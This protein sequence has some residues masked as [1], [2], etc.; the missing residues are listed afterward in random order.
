MRS[1]LLLVVG[2][3]PAGAA[4]A[5]EL[6][7]R[8]KP[9]RWISRGTGADHAVRLTR[10]ARS[11]LE[12][13]GVPSAGET[14]LALLAGLVRALG[15][16]PE[17]GVLTDARSG[18]DGVHVRIE[19]LDRAEELRF[20]AVVDASGAAR[21]CV[22]AESRRLAGTGDSRWW[23]GD[24]MFAPRWLAAG[25]AG[26]GHPEGHPAALEDALCHTGEGVAALL[27]EGAGE[28][29]M[30]RRV[31]AWLADRRAPAAEASERPRP[32]RS[33]AEP[34]FGEEPGRTGGALPPSGRRFHLVGL[35]LAKTGTT[36][37]ASR[38]GAY[39]WGHEAGFSEAATRLAGPP[40]PLEER[41]AWW[42]AR[43][44][45]YPLEVDSTSFAGHDA[46]A[47][48]AA[49]PEARFVLTWRDAPAWIDSWL[50]L[51]LRNGRRWGEH[52]WPAWQ[53]R[54]GGRLL[55]GFDAA[56]FRSPETVLSRL[57][58]LVPALLATWEDH[59]HQ[60]GAALP[61]GRS[62]VLR[63]DDLSR[64]DRA[65]AALVGVDP[66][67]LQ[68]PPYANRAEGKVEVFASRPA[69]R[70][71]VEARSA[72][73]A[74][75]LEPYV[76]RTG[77]PP[78]ALT[79]TRGRPARRVELFVASGCNLHCYFCCESARIAERRF[80]PWE[81]LTRR[82]DEAAD[83]GVGVVQFMGGEATLHPR[84]PDALRHARA[85][86]LSTYVI[87]NLL[88]WEDPGFAAAV[89]P[90]LDEVMVSQHAWGEAA[91][92]RVT[93]RPGWWARY[94]GALANARA[95]LRATVRA[96]TVLSRHSVDHLDRI[97]DDLLSLRPTTW[98]LGMGVPIAEARLDVLGE[99]LRLSEVAALRDR[100]EALADR[101]AASGCR[102]V[103]FCVPHCVLG[104]RLREQAHDLTV[105]HQ[106]LGDGASL[107]VNFWSQADYLDQPRP[108]TLARRR[109]E[110]CGTCARR[111]ICGGY[112][113]AYFERFGAG[114]LEPVP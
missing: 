77:S 15:R 78:L 56:W 89:A 72:L 10:A 61:E 113:S 50:N 36:T 82:L 90:W 98:V 84:F 107:T 54:F 85:R 39:R 17:P 68:G 81:E 69:L 26:L 9:A 51:L 2:G 33:P 64:A 83:R 8:G 21:A 80:L 28:R 6:V 88:R 112:F 18:P 74:R 32:V 46:Q 100:L 63:T 14:R 41:V 40:R 103:P 3:G 108:V 99:S 75:A 92:A 19:G 66:S 87:T 55:P 34:G 97:A 94:R 12:E 95:T 49:F 20:D 73:A 110:V 104:P 65:L 5:L 53:V 7:R 42:R 109:P 111:A 25:A 27:G 86:A 29:W 37:L 1:P 23:R 93:G 105:D 102:L 4:A 70:A 35:G 45:A 71:E 62:L 76:R 52:P 57:D 48:V 114:E 11:W 47:V 91:G 13:A 79:P 24:P 16:G 67:T 30:A 31:A 101:C 106:D 44:E 43:D 60:V 59:A 38:F 96:S 22:R 58:E